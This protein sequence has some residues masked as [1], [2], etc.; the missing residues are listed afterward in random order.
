MKELSIQLVEAA[1]ECK[2]RYK[3][4]VRRLQMTAH[5]RTPAINC[6][7]IKLSRQNMMDYEDDGGHKVPELYGTYN[8]HMPY[9]GA[10][11]GLLDMGVL[12]QR[13]MIS[14]LRAGPQR[15]NE[16]KGNAKMQVRMGTSRGQ[17]NWGKACLKKAHR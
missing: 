6:K 16:S 2:Q 3:I 17:K 14:L 7:P 12:T 13:L 15:A 1:I 10:T 4:M 8:G 9:C 11:Q 5:R